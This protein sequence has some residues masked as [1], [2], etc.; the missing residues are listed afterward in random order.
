MSFLKS[1]KIQNH[2]S[3]KKRLFYSLVFISLTFIAYQSCSNCDDERVPPTACILDK[4]EAFKSESSAFA[5]FEIDA[6]D[7]KF[8]LFSHS[9]PD[10]GDFV[11][12]AECEEVCITNVEGYDPG[13]IPC[14][15]GVYGSPRTKIWQK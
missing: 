5:V 6:P 10:A 1:I 13:M 8:Y 3:M 12:N 9:A 2:Y 4:I 11:Y 15:P 14:E 7:G